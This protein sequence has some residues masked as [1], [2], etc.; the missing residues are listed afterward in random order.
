MDHTANNGAS[1]V[2]WMSKYTGDIASEFGKYYK[3]TKYS[4][5]KICLD[6]GKIFH[7]HQILLAAGSAYFRGILE[8]NDDY[9]PRISECFC[10]IVN[11]L[12]AH[13]HLQQSVRML[14]KQMLRYSLPARR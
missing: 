1:N 10:V 8:K 6:D 13:R 7:S 11:C 5:I 12:F 3:S 4:D 9:S 14:E 2:F